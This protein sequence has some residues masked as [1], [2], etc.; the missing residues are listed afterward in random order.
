[1]WARGTAGFLAFSGLCLSVGLIVSVYFVNV[2][3]L[4]AVLALFVAWGF[5]LVFFRDPERRPEGNGILSAADGQVR[6]VEAAEDGDT[7]RVS[8]FM[9]V[10]NVHVNRFP[11]DARVVSVSDTGEGH[12]PAYRADA[13]HNRQRSYTLETAIG[14]VQVVQMTGIL[15]RRLVS[16][17]LPGE[18]RLRGERLGMIVLGSRVDVLLPGARCRPVVS[19]G[20]RVRAGQTVIA[21][22]LGPKD[23]HPG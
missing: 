13:H 21:R 10:T 11:I 6:A 15:A 9:N 4:G 17:V 22:P 20:M 8:V 1:M 3:A 12:R 5:L 7:W 14:A 2:V 16:F 23:G 18:R 19:V